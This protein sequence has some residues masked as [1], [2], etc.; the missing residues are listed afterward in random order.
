M[1]KIEMLN[2]MFLG[3]Q[4]QKHIVEDVKLPKGQY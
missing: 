4:F 3:T 2:R 1:K